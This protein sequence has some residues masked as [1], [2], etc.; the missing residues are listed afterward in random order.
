MLNHGSK[1]SFKA[2][3]LFLLSATSLTAHAKIEWLD[4]INVSDGLAAWNKQFRKQLGLRAAGVENHTQCRETTEIRGAYLCAMDNFDN[5]NLAL[6][7]A[8]YFIEKDPSAPKPL[9]D[10]AV[11]VY[12]V[13]GFDLKVS[14]LLRYYELM[15]QACSQNKDMCP[16]Q[17]EVEI[18]EDFILPLAQRDP[19][20]V[21]I[22]YSL[23]STLGYRKVVSHEI[24]H[25]Q[26]FLTPEFQ[27]IATEF[28]RNEVTT[29]DKEVAFKTLRQYY[30]V[31][32][33]FL[34]VNEFQAFMLMAG[35]GE[36]FLP[37]TVS[38]Y[39][40][41][42]MKRLNQAGIEPVQVQ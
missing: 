9:N 40:E 34:V 16:E 17:I 8:S 31:D 3:L 1:I 36:D 12:T 2:L 14:D 7:R 22:T 26:F 18:F 37:E 38:K 29:A 23:N 28:W 11:Q 24:L 33:E 42:L 5:M 4:P 32:D 30:N 39:R 13:D 35:A 6:K 21:L 15:S 20:A 25:A 27:R 41:P 10:S 19:T